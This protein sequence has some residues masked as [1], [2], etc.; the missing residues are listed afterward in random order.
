[1][2]TLQPAEGGGFTLDGEP[3][4]GG[5]V[6]LEGGFE[7]VVSQAA[8][9]TWMAVYQPRD[10]TFPL[11]ALGGSLTLAAREDGTFADA[12]GTQVVSGQNWEAAG[13]TYRLTFA[14]GAWTGTYVP[15]FPQTVQLGTQGPVEVAR[16]EDG[17]WWIG[18][19]ALMSGDTRESGANATGSANVYRLTLADGEWSAEYVPAIV[20][21]AGTDLDATPK[22]DG[23]GYLVEEATLPASG[24]GD[25][26]VRPGGVDEQYHVWATDDGLAGARFD[27][28]IRFGAVLTVNLK[29]TSE[30]PEL[31]GEN[32]KTDAT[33]LRT[34]VKA[35]G[36]DFSLGELLGA[37]RDAAMPEKTIL[38]EVR[39]EIAKLRD[40]VR[41]LVDLYDDDAIDRATFDGQISGTSDSNKWDRANTEIAKLFG[42]TVELERETSPR[43]VVDAFDALLDALATEEAFAA[44]TVKASGGVFEAAE[45][46]AAAAAR[47]FNAT[48]WS[49]EAV[50]GALGSTRFGAAKRQQR[51]N[52]K[53]TDFNAGSD[54]IQVFAWSTTDMLRRASE[55][56]ATGNATYAGRTHA[57]DSDGNLYS[58]DMSLSVRFTHERVDGL[59]SN[60]ETADGDRWEYGFGGEVQNIFLPT[61]RLQSSG[62]WNV[63]DG[64][65]R[66]T[67]GRRAGGARAVT[68]DGRAVW[69]GRL[70][71]RGDEAGSEAFGTWHI[72]DGSGTTELAGAF[73]AQ[74]GEDRPD[75]SQPLV[76]NLKKAG[77]YAT[78]A[79]LTVAIPDYPQT[80]NG[81]LSQE[82]FDV[83]GTAFQ[84]LIGRTF[85]SLDEAR[86]AFRAVSS[87]V[88]LSDAEVDE[89]LRVGLLGDLD[90]ELSVC[91]FPRTADRSQV[92]RAFDYFDYVVRSKPHGSR[93]LFGSNAD[94]AAFVVWPTWTTGQDNRALDRRAYLRQRFELNKETLF[95][96][97]YPI[98]SEDQDAA[99]SM[100]EIRSGTHVEVARKEIT[101]LQSVLRSVIALDSADAS[102]TD[103]RFANDR[104]QELFT[105]IQDQ[106]TEEVFGGAAADL[107]VFRTRA[108]AASDSSAWTAHVDYPVN[109]AGVAQDA[110][111]LSDIDDVIAALASEDALDAAFGT[112]GIF[113]GQNENRKYTGTLYDSPRVVLTDAGV[114]DADDSPFFRQG[115]DPGRRNFTDVHLGESKG[116]AV[117]L[118]GEDITLPASHIFS[119][120]QSRLLLVTDSTD[121]TRLGAWKSQ[122]SKYAT[123]IFKGGDRLV[124]NIWGGNRLRLRYRTPIARGDGL[125]ENIWGGNGFYN[126]HQRPESFAYSPL[127]QVAYSAATDRAYPGG[128]VAT[129]RGKT[130]A[131]QHTVFFTGDVELQVL[132]QSAWG[133]PDSDGAS[134]IGELDLTISNIVP[135]D[136]RYSAL[137]HGLP[138][139][140]PEVTGGPPVPRPGTYDVR[141]LAFEDVEVMAD[142]DG[143]V[144]FGSD[145]NRRVYVTHDTLAGTPFVPGSADHI[146][147][148][149]VSAT[150]QKLDENGVPVPGNA[151]M[152]A[153]TWDQGVRLLSQNPGSFHREAWA[154]YYTSG[155]GKGKLNAWPEHGA[156]RLKGQFV[157]KTGDGPSAAIG[158]WEISG[159]HW[160]GVGGISTSRDEFAK[161]DA[162]TGFNFYRDGDLVG[163]FGADFTPSP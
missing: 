49:A 75:P 66:V 46:G 121:F 83:D 130:V 84:A 111:L 163:S 19:T 54:K 33:E 110:Q 149:A 12:D 123:V 74:R 143:M 40:Q 20:P 28:P 50:F 30:V 43:R 92:A 79:R 61:A 23:S 34:T 144:S 13:N 99:V 44:A 145:A 117:T 134:K 63:K 115:P 118:E 17:S 138:D 159:E 131:V 73:G 124:E 71:G 140:Q 56:P 8:D 2:A 122:D 148:P 162:R 57:A 136:P 80:N 53:A 67:Y 10:V 119:K 72:Q 88:T 85:A 127:E 47:T 11:G 142:E 77:A 4:A 107:G 45:L 70:L 3:F 90:R 151:G 102:A 108:D 133:A 114:V 55:V 112:G 104:R 97:G 68:L 93:T 52:A 24:R 16:A 5:T 35:V 82:Q 135:T 105:Q 41:Q 22:E 157:G 42:G 51:A 100:H 81:L 126:N 87:P 137:R 15:P 132:W 101:R 113:A 78:R 36:T 125:V 29:G 95:G 32:T 39:D 18:E 91:C 161:G 109:G 116:M 146:R 147:V 96:E 141:S 14:D 150:L 6:T 103:R 58:G 38:R 94:A 65:A 21:I 98:V 153:D 155:P 69:I 158:T 76:D 37:G 26:T 154:Y 31:S 27:A 129:Y 7:Y 160:L 139:Y 89:V 59:V 60:L 106:L 120:A 62:R 128:T 25:V 1:M 48:R 9:G 152:I 156:A 86:G 64:D